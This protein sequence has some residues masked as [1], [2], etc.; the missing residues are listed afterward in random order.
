MEGTC[1]C[2]QRFKCLPNSALSFF[3]R[4]GLYRGELELKASVVLLRS[5]Y[6]LYRYRWQNSD[7]I[8]LKQPPP[9]PFSFSDGRKGEIGT[10][11]RRLGAGILRGCSPLSIQGCVLGQFRSG[12]EKILWVAGVGKRTG[13]LLRNMLKKKNVKAKGKVRLC[14]DWTWVNLEIG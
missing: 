10:D 3:F 4:G 9:P 12:D 1:L 11:S 14:S 5:F 7:F 8:C 13:W 6:H 2:L